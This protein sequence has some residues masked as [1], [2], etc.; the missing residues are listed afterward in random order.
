MYLR[1]FL[2]LDFS[3]EKKGLGEIGTEVVSGLLE[4]SATYPAIPAEQLGND[5]LKGWGREPQQCWMAEETSV[6]QDA[7]MGSVLPALP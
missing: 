2:G 7:K 4:G 1:V 6:T 3:R 5:Y